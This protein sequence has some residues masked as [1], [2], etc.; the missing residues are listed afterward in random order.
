MNEP[1]TIFE[2][3]LYAQK[4]TN[5]NIIA[6]SENLKDVYDR[7]NALSEALSVQPIPTEESAEDTTND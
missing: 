2:Q 1:R 7:I 4:A 6:L 5:D 3:I